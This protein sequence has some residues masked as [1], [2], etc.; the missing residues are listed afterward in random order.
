LGYYFLVDLSGLNSFWTGFFNTPLLG[1]SNLN[2]TVVLGS[3]VS[4]LILLW[5]VYFAMKQFII[6][7][8]EK[9]D[10]RLQKMKIVQVVK[11]SKLYTWYERI[12]N[13]GG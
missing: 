12:K 9:I 6:I 3:F 10:S 5:P 7:Y 8:R 4:A 13:F 2:N 1:L 11:G